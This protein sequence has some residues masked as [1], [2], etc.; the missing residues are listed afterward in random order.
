MKLQPNLL[1]REEGNNKTAVIPSLSSSR[2]RRNRKK[3]TAQLQASKEG[4]EEPQ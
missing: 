4:E 3:I 1:L 2:A